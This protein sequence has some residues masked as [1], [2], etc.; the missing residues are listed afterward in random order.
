M[1]VL[2]DRAPST[3]KKYSGAFL[4]WKKW[5]KGMH[6]EIQILPAKPLHVALYLTFLIQKSST[7]AP[8]EEAINALSWAHQ[9]ACEEDPT[10]CSLAKQVG[11]GAKRILAH[12]TCKEEPMTPQ[13][14][15]KLV[16]AFA[17][18]KASLSDV[19]M[20]GRFCGISTLQ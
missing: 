15:E 8:E 7:S 18:K 6:V 5:A 12:R 3:V 9:L 2:R 20:P 4:C 10:K 11:A 1:V 13:I 14:L 17:G 19:R 16:N